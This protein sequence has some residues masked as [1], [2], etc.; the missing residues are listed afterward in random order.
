ME[1]YESNSQEFLSDPQGSAGN[2]MD[3]L[4]LGRW[5]AH[6]GLFSDT[7]TLRMLAARKREKRQKGN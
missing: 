1:R 5:A 2:F 3:R 4:F 7:L 6:A